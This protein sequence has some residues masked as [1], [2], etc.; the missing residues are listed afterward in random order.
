MNLQDHPLMKQVMADVQAERQKQE[1]QKLSDQME[2]QRLRQEQGQYLN[3]QFQDA[4]AQYEG[5]RQA[6]HTTVGTVWAAAQAYARVTGVLPPGFMENV[7]NDI[8]LPS[9]V[10]GGSPWANHSPGFSTTRAS[11]MAWFANQGRRWE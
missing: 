5:E 9:M 1:Q 4:I 2:A 3:R 10:A 6:L 7:F 11:V 8:N